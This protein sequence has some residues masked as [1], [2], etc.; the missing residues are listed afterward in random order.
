MEAG[1]PFR[2]IDLSA[3]TKVGE[4]GNGVT[5]E[6]ASYPHLLLKVNNPHLA[7]LNTVEAEFKLSQAVAKLGFPTP[8]M[9]EI[10][11]VGDAYGV[12]QERIKDKK[13][14]FRICHD[15]PQ[16]IEEMARLFSSMA[17][18]IF[19][20]PCDTNFFPSRK[21]T[22]AKGLEMSHFVSRKNRVFLQAFLESVPENT[23]CLHGD[24]QA[25]NVILAD[26][27][28]YWIDL[29]RFA[30]GDPMFDIGHLYLSCVVYSKMKQAQNIFHL[31]REQL[32]L[33]W[34]VFAKDYTGKE[35]HSE[36][37]RKAACFAAADMLSRVY[38]QKPSW[39]ENLFFRFQ[40]NSLMRK[41]KK[42]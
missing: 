4:G 35:D 23:N 32:L 18:Q 28:P 34:D 30:W 29:G 36:F 10:V 1:R 12:I 3:W 39:L 2:T 17:K 19:N 11:L 37:D 33:F 5:Y 15:E 31:T 40:L 22:T 6:N 14:I 26:G 25:G 21:Q 8:A 27:K 20:T 13:S 42:G 7:D 24:F 9:Y 16:R 38:Y 41:I